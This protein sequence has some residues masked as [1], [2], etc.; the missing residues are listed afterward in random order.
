MDMNLLKKYEYIDEAKEQLLDF[1]DSYKGDLTKDQ[2][3]ILKNIISYI[4]AKTYEI[5]ETIKLLSDFSKKATKQL[6]ELALQIEGIDGGEASYK[7]WD[8]MTYLDPDY[9]YL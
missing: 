6:D 3:K 7:I 8:T 5:E 1:I 2:L 9:V 4:N